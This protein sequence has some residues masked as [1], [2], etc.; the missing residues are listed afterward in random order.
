MTPI[1]GLGPCFGHEQIDGAVCTH[2]STAIFAYY[3]EDYRGRM[4]VSICFAC[5][6]VLTGAVDMQGELVGNQQWYGGR[7]PRGRKKDMVTS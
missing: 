7:K 5:N 4:L 2:P 3:A 6:T 1:D